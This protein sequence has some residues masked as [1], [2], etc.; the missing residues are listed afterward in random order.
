MVPL[1]FSL[2]FFVLTALLSYLFLLPTQK[3]AKEGR[4]KKHFLKICFL[5]FFFFLFNFSVF[6]DLFLLSLFWGPKN[7][8]KIIIIDNGF[9]LD[10]LSQ[11]L[12]GCSCWIHRWAA[13]TTAKA[14]A[15]LSEFFKSEPLIVI[16]FL[17]SLFWVP[18]NVVP[19]F[20]FSFIF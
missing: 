7:K 9:Y 11:D 4:K 16:C 17:C 18:G 13:A 15:F 8:S 1:D 20:I 14:D 2:H 12:L 5:F 6:L 10:S 3:P 19:G